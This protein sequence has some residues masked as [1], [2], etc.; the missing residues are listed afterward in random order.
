MV[1]LEA[2]AMWSSVQLLLGALIGDYAVW[3]TRKAHESSLVFSATLA[4]GGIH[5]L[6]ACTLA[7]C[8]VSFL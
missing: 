7:F 1:G 3:C 5:R 4:L 8:H 6:P 2:R